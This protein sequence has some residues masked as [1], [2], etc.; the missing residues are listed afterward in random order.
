LDLGAEIFTVCLKWVIFYTVR[1]GNLGQAFLMFL[2][3]QKSEFGLNILY[4][5][6]LWIAVD[7]QT[8]YNAFEQRFD[9]QRNIV[10]MKIF[11]KSIAY[12]KSYS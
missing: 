3:L 2:L 9:D 1:A 11:E 7:F 8:I 10:W 12:F 5:L 6:F 4:L